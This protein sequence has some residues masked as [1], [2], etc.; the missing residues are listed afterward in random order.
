MDG[1][2][3]IARIFATAVF[4]SVA[5]MFSG[6]EAKAGDFDPAFY[7]QQYPDVVAALGT[8][9]AV[10]YNHY[11]TFGIKEHRFKNAFEAAQAAN[12]GGAVQMPDTYVDVDIAN[13]IL[14]YYQQGDAVLVS[15]V[16]TGNEAKGN[17]T[18]VGVF[19]IDT[20]V[21]GKYLVGPDWNVWV[22][23][24]MKFTGAVGIHDA[25]WRS[26]FGGD[27]YKYNGSHGCVNLPHDVAL[28]L[29][30]MVDIGTM[31]VVH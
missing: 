22:D 17:G 30:D 25:S 1:K 9:P 23:R 21:P 15:E 16:V 10:L 19:F 14:I 6:K 28:N 27:I 2:R 13:Q 31:V 7:A 29:Y 26:N 18:P 4:M 12:P 24:W 3:V 8:D 5:L 11:L 20:K